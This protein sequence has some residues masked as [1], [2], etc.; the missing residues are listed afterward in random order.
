MMRLYLKILL[1]VSIIIPCE[2]FFRWSL[3]DN[4]SSQL[5]GTLLSIQA[6]INNAMVSMISISSSD[7]SFFHSP[8]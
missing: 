4:K 5:S 8:F 6:D 7:F 1:I 3:S 2:L